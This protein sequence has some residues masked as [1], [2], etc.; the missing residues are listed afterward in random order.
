M[1]ENITEVTNTKNWSNFY[2]TSGGRIWGIANNE[3]LN[4]EAQERRNVMG[5]SFNTA[6][7]A[8]YTKSQ[9]EAWARLK[10]YTERRVVFRNGNPI[11]ELEFH[12]PTEES[13]TFDSDIILLANQYQRKEGI[14]A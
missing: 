12:L 9:I 11:I 5:N 3:K 1:V 6:E 8:C 4:G 13:G 2:I 7:E 14:C 10:K